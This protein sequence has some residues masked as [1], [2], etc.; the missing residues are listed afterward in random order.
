MIVKTIGLAAQVNQS[1]SYFFSAKV[2]II[3]AHGEQ[4]IM[5]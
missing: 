5:N 1:V 2:L 4:E 3:E